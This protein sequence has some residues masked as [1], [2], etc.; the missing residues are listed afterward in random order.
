MAAAI[1]ALGDR[2]PLGQLIFFRA[3]FAFVPILAMVWHGGGLVVLRTARPL[4]HLVRAG[5]GATSMICN[6]MALTLLPLADATVLN[7]AAPLITTALAAIALGERV[8]PYRWSAVLV[9][10]GGVL[11]A[12]LPHLDTSSADVTRILSPGAAFAL[13]GAFTSAWAMIAIRRLSATETSLAIVFYFMSVCAIGGALS[14]PFA[15]RAPDLIDGALLVSIGL[16]GGVG[17]VLMTMSYRYASA[18][19]LAPFDYVAIVWALALGL[20]LFGQVPDGAVLAGAAIVV[21]AGLFIVYR[22]RRLGLLATRAG[23]VTTPH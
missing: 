6:F 20:V 3:T 5:S 18:S 1:K 8:G 21:S 7:F 10:F 15:Y 14:L 16:T 22:E 2:Y 23:P 11:V 17:Q 4:A 9:G 13:V 19:T 12:S